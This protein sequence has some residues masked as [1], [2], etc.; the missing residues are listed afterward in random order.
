MFVGTS[1]NGKTGESC[2][3]PMLSILLEFFD[4]EEREF[5][6]FQLM[7]LDKNLHGQDAGTI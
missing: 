1:S 2:I 7:S 4:N 6:R 5:N 3:T